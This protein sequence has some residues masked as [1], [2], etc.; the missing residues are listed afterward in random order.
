[1]S[2]RFAGA[3]LLTLVSPLLTQAASFSYT[4]NFRQDDNRQSFTF[5]LN[6][7]STPTIVTLSYAGGTN[8]AS[9][10]ISR[11]GFDPFVSLFDSNGLLLGVQNDGGCPAVGQDS[12]TGACWDAFLTSPLPAG[13]Y[14]VVLTEAD[15]SPNGP[16]LADGFSRDGQG[17]FTGPAYLGQ[18]GSFL[19]ANPNQRTSAWALDILNV[20][21]AQIATVPEPASAGLFAGG[22]CLL[23]FVRRRK[24]ASAARSSRS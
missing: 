2:L 17:N 12:V 5:A 21:R 24:V 14:T 8:A 1:M 4:G 7:P 23:L 9:Q 6:S 3:V 11:G 22:C 15:N 19:D 10:Q 16:S 13:N 20:D 18:A